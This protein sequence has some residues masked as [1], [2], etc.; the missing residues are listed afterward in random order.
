[1]LRLPAGLLSSSRPL[2]RPRARVRPRWPCLLLDSMLASP[3]RLV[4]PKLKSVM[5]VWAG[6]LMLVILTKLRL[7]DMVLYRPPPGLRFLWPRLMQSTPMAL[8]TPSLLSASG[9]RFM[10]A[11]NSADPFMLPGLTMLMTL[12]CGSAKDR[13]LTSM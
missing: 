5:Q 1:M 9:L 4:F 12:P 3:R 2:F 6:I 7:L 10:T 13:L 11:P 8:L